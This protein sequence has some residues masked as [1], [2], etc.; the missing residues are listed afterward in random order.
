MRGLTSFLSGERTHVLVFRV[1]YQDSYIKA[2]DSS[3][4]EVPLQQHNENPRGNKIEELDT[5]KNV[6]KGLCNKH[7]ILFTGIKAH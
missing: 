4:Q 7:A 2:R 6:A 1:L 3:H 5:K